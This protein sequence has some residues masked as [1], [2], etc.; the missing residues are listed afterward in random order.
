LK[1]KNKYKIETEIE[2]VKYFKTLITLKSGDRQ[3]HIWVQDKVRCPEVRV[4]IHWNTDKFF[5]C[6][7]H[8]T[9]WCIY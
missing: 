1:L 2:A 9:D 6:T 3:V 5:K 4:W 7:E 8:S